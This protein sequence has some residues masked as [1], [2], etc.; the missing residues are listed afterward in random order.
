MSTYLLAITPHQIADQ[1]YPEAF[2]RMIS[3]NAAYDDIAWNGIVTFAKTQIGSLWSSLMQ[4]NDEAVADNGSLTVV[5]S[6][7]PSDHLQDRDRV[8]Y[9]LHR[10]SIIEIVDSWAAE[11]GSVRRDGLYFG[12]DVCWILEGADTA[13]LM[14]DFSSTKRSRFKLIKSTKN[15]NK[16]TQEN[17]RND[18]T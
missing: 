12:G 16:S 9:L 5:W 10:Q 14:A 2:T 13:G 3:C 8:Q 15:G 18:Q 6:V 1:E 17:S 7:N 4:M 11:L